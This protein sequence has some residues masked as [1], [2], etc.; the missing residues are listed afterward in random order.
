MKMRNKWLTI[1]FTLIVT[2]TMAWFDGQSVN[3]DPASPTTTAVTT[4][5]QANAP[6]L[7]NND[8]QSADQPAAND[9]SINRLGNTATQA[10]STVSDA[11]SATA[12]NSV[13]EPATGQTTNVSQRTLSTKTSQLVNPSET[14][15]S[16]A[17]Q[18]AVT[19]NSTTTSSQQ[20]SPDDVTTTLT[21]L[22]THQEINLGTPVT[23]DQY[24]PLQ[25]TFTYDFKG[26]NNVSNGDYFRFSFP[27]TLRLTSDQVHMSTNQGTVMINGNNGRFV[28]D[29]NVNGSD[30]HGYFY[31][32]LAVDATKAPANQDVTIPITVNNKSIGSWTVHYVPGTVNPNERVLASTQCKIIWIRVMLNMLYG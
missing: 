20:L 25:L 8:S 1:L 26:E 32:T 6:N 21:N 17:Q 5:E 24:T 12:D 4:P 29:K 16:D 13:Q 7:V 2:F 31:F 3:A 22:S 27:S 15:I 18:N 10:I 28:F 23:V 9:S 11:N 14:A 30:A 19:Q